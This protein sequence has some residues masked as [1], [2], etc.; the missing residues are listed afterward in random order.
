MEETKLH[1]ARVKVVGAMEQGRAFHEAAK[2]AGLEISQSTAYRL[3]QSMPHGGEHLSCRTLVLLHGDQGQPLRASMHRFDLHV[4]IAFPQALLSIGTGDRISAPNQSCGGSRGDGFFI[5]AS[6]LARW[7]AFDS[8]LPAP[9]QPPNMIAVIA[10]SRSV[11]SIT[12][13]TRLAVQTS[14]RKP[15]TSAPWLTTQESAFSVL[16]LTSEPCLW[17]DAH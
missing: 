12:F 11:C 6:W 4:T 3:R 5:A 13:A 17:E 15:Y 10:N 2:R 14:P 1:G 16:Q 8:S 9:Q 7:D